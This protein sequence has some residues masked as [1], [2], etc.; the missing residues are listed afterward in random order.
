MSETESQISSLFF[1]LPNIIPCPV[2]WNKVE[3][4]GKKDEKCVGNS[5]KNIKFISCSTLPPPDINF[6]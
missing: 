4:G 5:K 6:K 2:N 3:Q 1:L